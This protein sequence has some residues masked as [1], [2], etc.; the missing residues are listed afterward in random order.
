MSGLLLTTPQKSIATI[1]ERP[2]L[3]ASMYLVAQGTRNILAL[4][5]SHDTAYDKAIMKESINKENIDGSSDMYYI[6]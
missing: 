3:S 1:P 4:Q 2:A 5:R 6:F